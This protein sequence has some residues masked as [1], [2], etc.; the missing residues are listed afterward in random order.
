MSESARDR[1]GRG[2]QDTSW[3]TRL[4]GD[5]DRTQVR[6][7][8]ARAAEDEQLRAKVEEREE[9]REHRNVVDPAGAV[10]VHGPV[11][12]LGARRHRQDG[13]HFVLNIVSRV[14]PH[15]GGSERPDGKGAGLQRVHCGG[16]GAV[17]VAQHASL[18]HRSD[19]SV[20]T[21]RTRARCC[22]ACATRRHWS[23]SR[24]CSASP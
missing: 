4:T 20:K 5:N 24:S 16:A 15:D 3:M 18:R 11:F 23:G 6:R 14:K 10:S 2:G 8:E 22:I 21:Y 9:I 17:P 7:R 13:S 1:G 12:E 19:E